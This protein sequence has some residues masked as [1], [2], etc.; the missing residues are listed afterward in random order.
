MQV[1]PGPAPPKAAGPPRDRTR[2]GRTTDRRWSG[3]ALCASP[4]PAIY[5]EASMRNV[6]DVKS[7]L[8]RKKLS[9]E[10]KSVVEGTS[11]Q[12]RVDHG[13]RRHMKNKKHK[14]TLEQKEQMTY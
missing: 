9:L 12:V 11:G 8:M 3:C 10:R 5:P 7:N 14:T 6:S 1:A 2:P 13:G 4:S